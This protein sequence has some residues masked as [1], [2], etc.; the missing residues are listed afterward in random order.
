MPAEATRE[1]FEKV[2][3]IEVIED[4]L[5][6]AGSP[7]DLGHVSGVVGAFYLVGILSDEEYEGYVERLRGLQQDLNITQ[8][9]DLG[10]VAPSEVH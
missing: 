2:N 9:I 10:I 4:A 7:F 5:T 3:A 1:H 8:T 6:A